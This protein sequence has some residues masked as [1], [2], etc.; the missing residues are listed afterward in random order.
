MSGKNYSAWIIDDNKFND[1]LGD[2]EKL[3]H[4]ARYAI[5]AP[6]GHNTQPW[7]ISYGA[8]SLILRADSKR[9]LPYS[10]LKANEPL[11]SLGS[12][13]GVLVAVAKS[14]G[15]PTDIKLSPNKEDIATV[16]LG[17]YDAKL[18]DSEVRKAIKER[19]SDRFKYTEVPLDKII[20]KE[21]SSFRSNNVQINIIEDNDTKNKI[22]SLTNEATLST[23]GEK[24]FRKE[25]S[26]WVRN[27]KTNQYD[28]MPGAVQG[29]PTPPSMFA[30][31]I[32]K[33]L[34]VSKDQAK[35][36]TT[37]ILNSSALVI[38]SVNDEDRHSYLEGGMAYSRICVTAKK[39]GFASA[40]VGAAII[41]SVTREKVKEIL[42]TELKPIAIIRLGHSTRK[43]PKAP[44]Y[45]LELVES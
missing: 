28:G 18:V 7:A 31:Q 8:N 11:V 23:M 4:F 25:L 22:A 26:R 40:G 2:R 27:N 6:S 29:I 35:K 13:L 33:Y 12:F 16:V 14:F 20:K 45:P 15:Y 10:G 17:V 5:L 24:D 43:A 3:R 21:I 32:I 44:R 34:N 38:I 37:R 36:D 30:K 1:S 41:D 9:S 39:R 19:V 42:A